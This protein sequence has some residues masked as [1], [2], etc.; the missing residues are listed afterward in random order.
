MY[1]FVGH[2]KYSGTRGLKLKILEVETGRT[3]I[4]ELITLRVD[5]I[6]K[7]NVVATLLKIRTHLLLTN[8]IGIQ[9]G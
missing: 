5:A 1:S 9:S 4:L 6:W 8:N 2:M 7:R 3:S